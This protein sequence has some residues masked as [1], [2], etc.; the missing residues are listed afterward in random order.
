MYRKLGYDVLQ[1]KSRSVITH[2]ETELS[3]EEALRT[4]L[5]LGD[6]VLIVGEVR[7]K[8]S[9]VLFEAMRIGALANVVAGTI[10]G[11]S[12]YGV[13]DRV[14]HDLGVTPTSFKALDLIS[15]SNILKTPDGL[16]SFRRVTELTEVRK[17]WKE[18]P[19]EEG[20][21]IPL[22]EYSAKEDE[23]KP[24]DTLINGESQVLDAIA[25]RTREWRGAWDR[26]WDNILLRARIKK[27]IVDSAAKLNKPEILEAK[28]TIA[29]NEAFHL[30]SNQVLQ[31]VGSVDSK[32]VYE[33]WLNWFKERLK[34][35]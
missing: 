27:T 29:A 4:A 31:E 32:L 23:L 3:P 13:Y 12:A 10:H 16:R 18:D 33:K 20:G 9:A 8:E 7:S 1:L 14:V 5:R 24:T 34:H 30:I 21:F 6:S 22:L 25:K 2:V 26:V 28:W 15:I 19:S 35:G 17:K 11:E